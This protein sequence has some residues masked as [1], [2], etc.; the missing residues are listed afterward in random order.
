MSD[1]EWEAVF[2]AH[3]RTIRVTLILHGDGSALHS[4]LV[5]RW[6]EEIHPSLMAAAAVEEPERS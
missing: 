6:W 5:Q 1:S 2:I 4:H 3:G